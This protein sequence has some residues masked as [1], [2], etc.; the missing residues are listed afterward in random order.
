RSIP[1]PTLSGGEQAAVVLAKSGMGKKDLGHLWAMS[2]VDRD[3]ALSRMEFSIA[4]HLASCSAK[5]GL[6]VPRALPE[7]LGALLPQ[8]EVQ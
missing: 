2:D 8:P 3:G 4:M 7:S 5:K 6:P 1:R